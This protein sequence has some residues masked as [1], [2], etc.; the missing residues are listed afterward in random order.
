MGS[1][2]LEAQFAHDMPSNEFIY[3]FYTLNYDRSLDALQLD[4]QFLVR[5]LKQSSSGNKPAISLT[6]NIL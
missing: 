3:H 4:M 2:Q 1:K 5:V 6:K